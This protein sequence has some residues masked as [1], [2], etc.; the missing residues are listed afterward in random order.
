M[1]PYFPAKEKSGAYDYIRGVDARISVC[2]GK[3]QASI[4]SKTMNNAWPTLTLHVYHII[5]HIAHHSYPEF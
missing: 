1:N 2:Y 5:Y 3:G 4:T